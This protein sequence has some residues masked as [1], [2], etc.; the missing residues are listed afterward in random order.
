MSRA[1]LF[2]AVLLFGTVACPVAHASLSTILKD[3][4]DGW[5]GSQATDKRFDTGEAEEFEWQASDEL[6]PV[7]AQTSSESPLD[8]Q[9]EQRMS[10]YVNA[11]VDGRLVAFRDVPEYAWFA[12]YV[13]NALQAGIV[14]GYKDHEGNPAGLFGPANGVTVEELAKIAVNLAGGVTSKCPVTPKNVEAAKSWSARYVS[15]AENAGWSVYS[16][17]TAE[18]AAPATRAQVVVTLLQA[19]GVQWD[20]MNGGVFTDV[21]DAT[22]FG[23]AI[24]KAK[25]DGLVNG[26]SDAAGTPTGTFGPT[27]SVKRAEIAKMAMN[28]RE[29]YGQ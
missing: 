23:A 18:L 27:D 2:A 9:R 4:A 24:E 17:G 21:T 12:P 1:R 20:D 26:Y 22:Q 6:F 28:A 10:G 19:Y 8:R 15:C 7:M 11:D 29:L 3:D 13:R 25:M 5:Y 14:S 16:D